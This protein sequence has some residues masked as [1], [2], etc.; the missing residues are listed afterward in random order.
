M[1]FE[2][3]D[4]ILLLQLIKKIKEERKYTQLLKGFPREI[5]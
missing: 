4:V 3:K 2:S 5:G 1:N